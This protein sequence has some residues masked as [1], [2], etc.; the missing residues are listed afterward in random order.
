MTHSTDDALTEGRLDRL[1]ALIERERKAVLAQW[2]Q[3]VCQL[4]TAQGLDAPALDDHVPA[5]LDELAQAFRDVS[6]ETIP[7]IVL[8]GSPPTHG[9]QR[10]LDGFDIV[11]VVAEYN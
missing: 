10:L 2:R 1:A 11:E 9:R 7:D 4:P 3:Q 8:Q 5:L 6:V